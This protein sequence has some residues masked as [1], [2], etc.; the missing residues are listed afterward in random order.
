[1]DLERTLSTANHTNAFLHKVL[2]QEREK[3]NETNK[4]ILSQL[5]EVLAQVS[6]VEKANILP[7]SKSRKKRKHEQYKSECTLE[8][9][10]GSICANCDSSSCCCDIDDSHVELNSDSSCIPTCAEKPED[11]VSRY[12][13]EMSREDN[14]KKKTDKR[15]SSFCVSKYDGGTSEHLLYREFG[16]CSRQQFKFV[17]SETLNST[18]K[19]NR[20]KIEC[21]DSKDVTGKFA[22]NSAE[23]RKLY[24]VEG[25]PEAVILQYKLTPEEVKQIPRFES[26]SPG[27]PSNVRIHLIC[28]CSFFYSFW[29]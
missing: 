14:Q 11:F 2:I 13:H 27:E 10:S 6:N 15:S 7:E 1:M 29:I 24:G 4:E 8:C 21:K 26:Y 17:E 22:L 18:D 28:V 19:S 25:I 3:T 20:T 12:D 23:V 5:P 16:E 9:C